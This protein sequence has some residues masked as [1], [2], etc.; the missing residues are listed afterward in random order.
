MIEQEIE[1]ELEEAGV[2]ILEMKDL[3]LIFADIDDQ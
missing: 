1:V 3:P 2:V